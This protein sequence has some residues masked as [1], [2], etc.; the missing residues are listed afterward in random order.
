MLAAKT[1]KKSLNIYSPA[2]LMPFPEYPVGQ[3]PQVKPVTLAGAGLSVHVTPL[4]QGCPFTLQ[5]SISL[6][7]NLPVN[8]GLHV[9]PWMMN[10]LSLF[11]L[12][13]CAGLTHWPLFS[14][15]HILI[16]GVWLTEA[17]NSSVAV[18]ENL[19]RR[20]TPHKCVKSFS[21]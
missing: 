8:P 18:N 12:S 5:A 3:D 7:Q 10:L 21:F 20:I 13:P 9:Q 11:N 6:S 17:L 1:L 19:T 2:H 16:V 4:K 14:Q 15:E